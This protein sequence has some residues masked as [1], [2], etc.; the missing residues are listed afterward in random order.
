MNN[1]TNITKILLLAAISSNACASYNMQDEGRWNGN[2]GIQIGASRSHADWDFV[3]PNYFDTLGPIL[4]E[5]D[6]N[7]KSNGAMGGVHLGFDYQIDH[8]LFG[9]E[10]AISKTDLEVEQPSVFFPLSDINTTDIRWYSTVTGRIGYG[11]NK[12]LAYVNGGWA[13]AD[14]HLSM[15]DN[16]ASILASSSFWSNGWVLG[17]GINYE[18]L[19][20]L[21]G[22][23]AYE[24]VKLDSD[25]KTIDCPDCGTG[26]GGG[27]PV[28][29]GDLTI[30]TIM[31]R[32]SYLFNL[33]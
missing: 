21:V 8:L 18:F 11:V 2:V 1:S 5:N 22:G 31:V 25:D 24:V 4:V 28:V 33:G 27:T 20:C 19:P 26:I 13:G 23:I 3:N 16:Q 32:L 9:I 15:H 29:D 6:F 7:L 17:G 30:H 12:W 14:V 10:G